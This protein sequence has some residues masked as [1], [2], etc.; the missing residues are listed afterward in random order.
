MLAQQDTR[1]LVERFG[2]MGQRRFH[3]E[4]EKEVA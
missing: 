1:D 2:Q 4:L 3:L